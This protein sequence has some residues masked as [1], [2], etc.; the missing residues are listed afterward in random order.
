MSGGDLGHVRHTVNVE[1]SENH[2]RPGN[3]RSSEGSLSQKIT[4]SANL[5]A[6]YY[7]CQKNLDAGALKTM[8]IVRVA[9]TI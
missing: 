3:V 1:V 2:V 6:E 7:D 9:F 5:P 4:G 8:T